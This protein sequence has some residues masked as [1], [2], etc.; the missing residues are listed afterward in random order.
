MKLK[1]IDPNTA[2]SD[3]FRA[4]R[5]YGF[6]FGVALGLGFSIFTWGMD[7]IALS[8]YHGL[9]PWV[10]FMAGSVTSALAGGIAGWLT[11]RVNK[12]L[13]GLVIW[14]VTALVFA[15]LTINLPL[16]FAPQAIEVIEP[17]VRGLLHYEYFAEFGTRVGVAYTWIA[18]CIAIAGL[19]QLPLSD[20][21]VFSTSIMTKLWP[22]LIAVVLMSICG[23]IV[24]NSM[25]NE[26]LRS[27]VMAADN[28]I[29]FLVDNQGKEMDK[30]EARKMHVGAFR[31]TMD[32]VSDQRRLVVS[33]FDE[34]LGEIKV[35][36]RFEKG[37]VECL[38]L[39]NQPLACEKVK[40]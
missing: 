38:V 28:T 40:G 29:Q 25:I 26:P 36:V 11:A 21:A 14:L 9:Y 17:D 22:M 24:D 1:R 19:L 30:A 8:R 15:W 35:L 20:S 13:P 7:A 12:S 32:L 4:K 39:Y 5:Q 6:W 16:K 3:I 31:T 23:A 33:G 18:I 27:A 37:W 34:A 2:R 10:K